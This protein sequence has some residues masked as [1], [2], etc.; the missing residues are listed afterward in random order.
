MKI[1]NVSYITKLMRG[2]KWLETIKSYWEK[3]FNWNLLEIYIITHS[4]LEHNYD[5]DDVRKM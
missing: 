3:Y 5:A 2:L 1:F 4:F